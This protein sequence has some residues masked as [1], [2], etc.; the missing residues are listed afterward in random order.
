MAG[1]EFQINTETVGRQNHPSV[2]SLSNGGFVV[3]WTSSGQDGDSSGVYGQRYDSSGNTVDFEFQI[4]THTTSTQSDPSVASL[5]DGGF[6]VAWQSEDQ[7]GDGFGIF[8]QRYDSSA[9]PVGSEFLINTHTEG[10]QGQTSAT[11][12]SD[13]GFVVTWQSAGQDGGG[14][15]VFGKRYDANGDLVEYNSLPLLSTDASLNVDEDTA[16]SAIAFS[17]TDADEDALSYTFSTPSK[18]SVTNNGNGTYTYMPAANENGTDS[19][20]VTV[21]DTTD[22]VSQ[23]VDVTIN[24]VNDAP[25]LTTSSTLITNE[26][27][28]S[29]A[30]AF[31]AT[32][33]EG[34]TLSYSFS[35][36]T[37]GAVAK[38]GNGTYTYTPASNESGSDSFTVTVNDGTAVVSQTVD[39][40]IAAVQDP[41][42]GTA[43]LV[44][45]QAYAGGEIELDTTS[46][47]DPDGLGLFQYQWQS[48][49]DNENWSAITGAVGAKFKP[50]TADLGSYL[51]ARVSFEDGIGGA[52]TVYSS[53][54]LLNSNKLQES[55]FSDTLYGTTYDDYVTYTG[56]ADKYARMLGAPIP[57]RSI[58]ACSRF[59]C[60]LRRVGSHVLITSVRTQAATTNHSSLLTLKQFNFST[61]TVTPAT[62]NFAGSV[63]FGRSGSE[64][65]TGDAG[66][67][68]FDPAGGNDNI[69]GGD[70]SDTVVFFASEDDFDIRSLEGITKFTSNST[71]NEYRYSAIT[72]VSVETA[73]F[74]NT[75]LNLSV[76]SA[77]GYYLGSD[78]SDSFNGTSENE[79]F[80]VGGG[81]NYVNGGAGQDAVV[82]FDDSSNY[83]VTNLGAFVSIEAL[84]TSITPSSTTTLKNVE[85]LVFTDGERVFDVPEISLIEG[86]PWGEELQGT[87]SDDFFDTRGG[88]DFI[89]GLAGTDEILITESI[90]K[91]DLLELSGA[92]RLVGNAEAGAYAN[93]SIYFDNV[94]AIGFSDGA[95]QVGDAPDN[96]IL[97]RVV[98]EEIFGTSADDLIDPWGGSDVIRGGGGTDTLLLFEDAD[99]FEVSELNDGSFEITANHSSQL[100]QNTDFRLYDVEKVQ[101]K[102]QITEL[103]V[104]GLTVK[105]DKSYVVEGSESAILQISL[106]TAP[107]HRVEIK[108]STDSHLN[109]S[110]T[111]LIFDQSN[112]SI[113]KIISISAVDDNISEASNE[114]AIKFELK[115]DDPSYGSFLIDPIDFLV[116]DD[117]QEVGIISGRVWSDSNK[118]GVTDVG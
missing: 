11:S 94:E 35:T 39:V 43:K 33:I 106:K 114:A 4:N 22:N 30:I 19:F 98:S 97:G 55:A 23:T 67:D 51:R 21:N 32:D 77:D 62:S 108:L 3:T 117:D 63:H 6:V 112:W 15:G 60:R 29:S 5:K 10:Y 9:S 25:V 118:D 44:L 78:Y 65:L 74:V 105:L 42:S 28:A 107:T 102:D 69:N 61:D 17:A 66:S 49:A 68:L 40:T 59:Q 73:E 109:A 80:D 7:D 100:Y 48:S 96:L 20:T 72:T 103:L 81:Q 64:T 26:D 83:I 91:F 76:A 92:S 31:S 110:Q 115:S 70:G 46:I 14:D 36:P 18:G 41:V 113:P 12:L 89:D 45:D 90:T 57:Q 82:I 93:D 47:S 84:E 86:N 54:Y 8:G 1:S 111:K 88:H 99:K 24:A 37:K 95:F 104:P 75:S 53:E 79:V 34:D 58:C 2:T 85:R 101:F 116:G 13:G 16:S 50:T 27:T 38:N 52:E 87:E 56:G 71:T